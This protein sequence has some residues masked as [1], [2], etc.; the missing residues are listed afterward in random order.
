V[1][2]SGP[3]ARWAIVAAC[4]P[5]LVLCACDEADTRA[6]GSSHHDDVDGGDTDTGD[7]DCSTIPDAPLSV[8]Q[9]EGAIGYR[10]VAFDDN[11]FLAGSDG[12]AIYLTVSSGSSAVFV[13]GLPSDTGMHYLPNGDLIVAAQETLMRITPDGTPS[14]LGPTSGIWTYG[15]TAGPDGM[16]YVTE[17]SPGEGGNVRRVDPETGESE[18]LVTGIEARLVDFTP[19]LSQMVIVAMYGAIYAVDLDDEFDP[20][21]SP[22]LFTT[23]SG[24][25]DPGGFGVDICGNIYVS[26]HGIMKLDRVSPE[27]E[28][29]TL[30]DWGDESTYGHGLEWGSGVGGWDDR[31]IYLPQPYNGC[32]VV[33]LEIGVPHS[34]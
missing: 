10:D 16:L 3:C 13:Y 33:R 32:S 31:S 21:G 6:G 11:G 15:V 27:G 34:Y 7:F 26:D 4:A 14:N 18:T 12:T 19:D 24:C 2:L 29:T 17:G 30:Y 22:T 1:A 25:D 28:I 20:V 8:E 23:I 9:V 5:L